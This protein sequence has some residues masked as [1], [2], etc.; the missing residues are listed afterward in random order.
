MNENVTQGKADAHEGLDLYRPVANP[1]KNIPLHGE[2]QWP[3]VPRF[4]EKYERWIDKMQELGLIVMEACV[5]PF[6]YSGM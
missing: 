5:P 4:R 6:G 2:N 1:D 3:D